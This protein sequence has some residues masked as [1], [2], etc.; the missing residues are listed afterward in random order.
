MGR[1]RRTG[2]NVEV[3]RERGEVEFGY[4]HRSRMKTWEQRPNVTH[5][6]PRTGTVL[7]S[8]VSLLQTC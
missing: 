2:G 7:L 8:S 6:R 4:Q 1:R 5:L 3:E